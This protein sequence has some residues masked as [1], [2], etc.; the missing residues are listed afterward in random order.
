MLAQL[1]CSLAAGLD[2]RSNIQGRTTVLGYYSPAVAVAPYTRSQEAQAMLQLTVSLAQV[3]GGN[4]TSSYC[5]GTRT[6]ATLL[7][8]NSLSF[9]ARREDAS[10]LKKDGTAERMQCRHMLGCV[11]VLGKAPVHSQ[12]TLH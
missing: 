8:S 5:W 3:S 11:T 7:A 12:C 10:M 2:V 4:A 1:V 6:S 9:E